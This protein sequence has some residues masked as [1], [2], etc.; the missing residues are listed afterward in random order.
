MNQSLGTS[1]FPDGRLH[2][3]AQLLLPNH[4]LHNDL[5][6]AIGNSLVQKHHL[7]QKISFYPFIM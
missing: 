7:T 6:G 1:L 5:Y 4:Y 2:D 3:T